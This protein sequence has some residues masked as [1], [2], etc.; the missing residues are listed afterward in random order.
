MKEKAIAF[1]GKERFLS[2]FW[3]CPLQYNGIIY[4]SVEHAYQA[5][6]TTDINIQKYI[7][8]L[9]TPFQA[10]CFGKT[11]QKRSDWNQIKLQI[12]YELI[13]KKFSEN[14]TLKNLLLQTQDKILVEKNTWGD[15]FWG[16]YNNK[17]EN[18]LG[19]I[20]MKVRQELKA[21]ENNN[22]KNINN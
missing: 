15:T 9:S 8:Q 4:P 14:L 3:Q 7:S 17:G 2:N 20:L 11:I 5:Q 19:K 16:I 12:M 1:T 6:K 22:E 21:K 10:K 13:S 18:Y